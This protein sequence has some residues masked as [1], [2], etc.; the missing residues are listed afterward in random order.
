MLQRLHLI[1]WAKGG[2]CKI[3]DKAKIKFRFRIYFCTYHSVQHCKAVC[4]RLPC[5]N[6]V[7]PHALPRVQLSKTPDNNGNC[8]R[9]DLPPRHGDEANFWPPEGCPIGAQ[10]K[11]AASPFRTIDP[12]Q[13]PPSDEWAITPCLSLNCGF[14]GGASGRESTCQCRR[15][16][17]PRFNPWVGKITRRREWQPAAIFLPGKSH[18]QRSLAGYSPCGLQGI[19]HDWTTEQT[20]I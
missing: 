20:L 17:R 5:L 6:P 10:L 13:V 1:I 11:I 19:G 3:Q 18:G 8:I 7:S 12:V 15:L 14:P 16:K 9:S 2:Y 4:Q